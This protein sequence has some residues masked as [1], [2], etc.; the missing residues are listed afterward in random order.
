MRRDQ[1]DW[2][3]IAKHWIRIWSRTIYESGLGWFWKICDL[4][5]SDCHM[6]EKVIFGPCSVNA[7]FYNL[8][9]SFSFVFSLCRH[10]GVRFGISIHLSRSSVSSILLFATLSCFLF[11]SY[12][13]QPHL[14]DGNVQ[15]VPT[16]TP[17]G[18]NVFSLAPQARSRDKTGKLDLKILDEKCPLAPKCHWIQ[19]DHHLSS[20][21]KLYLC[22]ARV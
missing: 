18:H 12:F 6:W 20:S 8:F 7:A 5:C 11:S 22:L 13:P 4:C 2:G 1:S 3:R 14:F 10:S 16:Q 9:F 19:E 17:C 15:S 21:A